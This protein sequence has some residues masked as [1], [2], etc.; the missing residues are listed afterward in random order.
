MEKLGEQLGLNIS[1]TSG[2][3]ENSNINIVSDGET[4]GYHMS[5]P[6]NEMMSNSSLSKKKLC[7]N[8]DITEEPIP[9]GTL[10]DISACIVV[11]NLESTKIQF[12]LNPC[13]VYYLIISVYIEVVTFNCSL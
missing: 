10:F 12:L 9:D 4:T 2:N 8:Q 1:G 6:Q 7:A 3:E 13:N 5:Y 11:W